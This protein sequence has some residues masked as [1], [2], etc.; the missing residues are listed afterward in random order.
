MK[1]ISNT[2]PSANGGNIKC[3]VKQG[4]RLFVY[5]NWDDRICILKKRWFFLKIIIVTIISTQLCFYIQGSFPLIP[6]V[7]TIDTKAQ[8]YTESVVI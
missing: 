5:E 4:D 6:R 3:E 7:M 8:R 1:K 2:C